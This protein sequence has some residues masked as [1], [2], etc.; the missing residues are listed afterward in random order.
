LG[1]TLQ[2]A[3]ADA[4]TTKSRFLFGHESIF[5]MIEI[6]LGSQ[7]VHS[8]HRWKWRGAWSKWQILYRFQAFSSR[9]EQDGAHAR[10]SPGIFY[11]DVASLLLTKILGAINCSA[12]LFKP[13][14][15][16]SMA[17]HPCARI[18]SGMMG[19]HGCIPK[20]CGCLR[21]DNI[22]PYQ[23]PQMVWEDR[24]HRCILCVPWY[25]TFFKCCLLSSL[26]SY[27]STWSKCKS[28]LC[29]EQMGFALLQRRYAFAW[30]SGE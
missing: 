1:I 27:C 4:S 17:H 29:T 15:T 25:C 23:Y 13:L 9:M 6:L 24:R 14:A 26:T 5:I 11:N 16:N 22:R 28:C 3:R 8:A 18:S 10:Y 30:E 20:V 19:R 21:F 7:Q 12:D 2:D